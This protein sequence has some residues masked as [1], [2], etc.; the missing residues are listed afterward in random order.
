MSG[1]TEK[2]VMGV[3]VGTILAIGGGARAAG[4]ADA[5]PGVDHPVAAV[6][7]ALEIAVGGGYLQGAGDV[8]ESQA[9]VDDLSGP[10][11][12]LELQIGVRVTP[13]LV[14]GVYGS[15]SRL[16]TG[17]P[18]PADTE[19]S[20]ATLG[21][22]AERHFRPRRSIDP[23]IGLSAGW[24]G[25][26]LVPASGKNTSFHGVDFARVQVGLDYRF[27]PR[28]AI[29]PVLGVSAGTFLVEDGPQSGGASRP[30]DPGVHIFFFGGLQ[31][32]FDLLGEPRPPGQ[33]ERL[34]ARR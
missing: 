25:L 29:G 2:M 9:T 28:L 10:G 11:S 14:L 22:F 21:L 3:V 30:H 13:L 4:P 24:R 5:R 20:S 18:L 19:V 6:D 8:A 32:R 12:S 16:T 15:C 26:W 17:G 27:S 7:R 33:A 23:W 1:L 34:Q 31:A